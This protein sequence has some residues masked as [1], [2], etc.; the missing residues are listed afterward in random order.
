MSPPP[1]VA[2]WLLPAVIWFRAVWSRISPVAPP[3]ASLLSCSN[4]PPV[5]VRVVEAVPLLTAVARPS[6]TAEETAMVWLA[7][8]RPTTS[9]PRSNGVIDA[10]CTVPPVGVVWVPAKFKLSAPPLTFA[11]TLLTRLAWPRFTGPV[12]R[13]TSSLALM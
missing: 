6:P 12:P 7:L 3:L 4:S 1:V 13:I 11:A 9:L 2:K 8:V 10:T 5:A